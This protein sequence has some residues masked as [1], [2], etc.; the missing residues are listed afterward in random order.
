MSV[1]LLLLQ[2]SLREA[3][4]RRLLCRPTTTAAG[5]SSSSSSPPPTP[6][7]PLVLYL[8]HDIAA[9]LVHLHAEGIAHGDIK[10]ANVL[11]TSGGVVGEARRAAWA[12]TAPDAGGGSGGGVSAAPVTAAAGGGLGVGAVRRRRLSAGS[13]ASGSDG[14]RGGCSRGV[15]LTAKLTD[16]GLAVLNLDANN[17]ITYGMRV[18]RQGRGGG[19]ARANSRDGDVG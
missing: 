11:L 18:R 17:H 6:L 5:A 19:G 1:L 16:F 10:A 3:L 15:A 9:A 4:D 8:A 12:D 13:V 14:G 2:G 7:L